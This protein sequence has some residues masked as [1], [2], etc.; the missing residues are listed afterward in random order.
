MGRARPEPSEARAHCIVSGQG[1]GADAQRVGARIVGTVDAPASTVRDVGSEAE[2]GMRR[3]LS[4]SMRRA[5]GVALLALAVLGGCGQ[6]TIEG[7]DDLG[8]LSED[9]GAGGET[10]G[11]DTATDAGGGDAVGTDDVVDAEA[12]AGDTAATDT[13]DTTVDAS[14]DDAADAQADVGGD[15]SVADAGDAATDDAVDAPDAATT[16]CASAADCADPTPA[17]DVATGACIACIVDAHC[18]TPHARCEAGACLPPKVCDDDGDC[19]ANKGV[20][21]AFDFC[22]DC[23]ED[24]DCGTGAVCKVFQCV[25]AGPGCA[26]AADCGSGEVCAE[27]LCTPPVCKPG[28][29]LCLQPDAIGSCKDGGDGWDSIGCGDG[30]GCDAAAC[31]PHVCPPGAKACAGEAPTFCPAN[32][33]GWQIAAP[34][35]GDQKCIDGACSSAVCEPGQTQCGSDGA[36]QTCNS[37]QTGWVDSTCPSGQACN[38]GVCLNV[39]CTPSESFCVGDT[40]W[41]CNPTGTSKT[42]VTDCSGGGGVCAEGACR[43]IPCKA[44]E[45]YCKGD[46]QLVCEAGTAWVTKTCAGAGDD[47]CVVS[48]CDPGSKQCKTGAQKSCDDGNPCTAGSC[49]AATG[50]CVQKPLAVPGGPAVTCDDGD[51]CTLV[52]VCDGTACT[53]GGETVQ[54]FSGSKIPGFVDGPADKARFGLPQDAARRPDGTL[55]VADRNNHRIRAVAAD[56]S[57]STFAGNGSAGYV[58]GPAAFAQMS[59]PSGIDVGAGWVVFTDRNN[60]RV[61]RISPTGQVS[62]FAGSGVAGDADGQGTAAQLYLPEGIVLAADGTMSISEPNRHRLRRIDAAGKVVTLAGSNKAGFADGK[63]SAALFNAP[64]GVDLG[65]SGLLYVADVGNHRIRAVAA[66]GTVTTVAGIGGGYADGAGVVAKFNGP[67]D[68]LWLPPVGKGPGALLIA[69][70]GNAVLR[71]ATLST[72]PANQVI[73]VVTVSGQAGKKGNVDGPPTQARWMLPGGLWREPLGFGVCDANAYALRRQVLPQ[74]ACD[75]GQPCT[76]DSCDKATGA[77]VHTPAAVGSACDDGDACTS[78]DAC[79]AKGLCLGALG[80]CDDGNACTAD[81]CDPWLG[82]CRHDATNEPCDDGQPCTWGDHC[83]GGACTSGGGWLAS[84]VGNGTPQA[85]DGIGPAA[86]LVGPARMATAAD[87]AVWLVDRDGHRVRRL[88]PKTLSLTTVAGGNGG[89]LDGTGDKARFNQPSGLDVRPDGAVVVADTG[90]HRL[91]LCTAAGVVTTLAGDGT[92]GFLDGPAAQARLHTPED[93]ALGPK[94]AVYVA[95]GGNRRIRRL[96]NGV[97]ETLA[98]S[99][100]VGMVDGT[101]AAARFGWPGGLLLEGDLLYVADRDNHRIRRVALGTGAVDT[102]IGSGKASFVDGVGVDAA[103]GWPIDLA[104]GGDGRLWVGSQQGAIVEVRG[105]S[106]ASRRVVGLLGG[107]YADG[108]LATARLHQARGL[109][110]FGDGVLVADGSNRRLR[111][112]TPEGPACTEGGPCQTS[113]SCDAKTGQ[114]VDST[115]KDGD[116]CEAGVC[117]VGVCKAGVCG[118]L[119]DKV[120][121]DG[122]ACTADLCDAAAGGCVHP[123][124]G[125][126]NGCCQ[127]V[128]W[129]ESFESEVSLDADPASLGLQWHVETPADATIPSEGKKVLRFG[130]PGGELAGGVGG[131]AIGHVRLAPFVVPVG[132]VTTLKVPV[133]FDVSPMNTSSRVYVRLRYKGAIANIGTVY[134]N[135]NGWQLVSRDLSPLAGKSVQLELRGQIPGTSTGAGIR[136]DQIRVEATCKAQTCSVNSQCNVS[137][138]GCMAGKCTSAACVMADN[139]CSNAD[140]CDDGKPC[141][142]DFC[143]NGTCVHEA[144]PG[145]C[146]ADAD[147]GAVDVCLAGKCNVATSACVYDAVPGCCHQDGDCD[148]GKPCTEDRCDDKNQCTYKELCCKTAADCSDGISCSVES[149]DAGWCKWA[150]NEASTCCKPL[151]G[152]EPAETPLQVVDWSRFKCATSSTV[153]TGCSKLAIGLTTSKGWQFWGASGLAHGGKGVLYYGDPSAKN[154]AFGAN[155]EALVSPAWKVNQGKTELEA[156][157]YWDT[158]GGTSYDRLLAWLWVDGQ[159]V[160]IGAS[161]APTYGAFWIKGV[162]GSTTPKTWQRIAVDVS[163][164]VGKKVQLELFFNTVDSAANTGLGVLLDDVR[165]VSTCTVGGPPATP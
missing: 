63:G 82:S 106:F 81:S 134:A 147:C 36:L 78:K 5:I 158:E 64:M 108:P 87:G 43:T 111:L 83:V 136:V 34:C 94:G 102:V 97:L 116:A 53:L 119:K 135:K 118:D 95:D 117:A 23:T 56:G 35:T 76:T 21:A 7:L 31:A 79:D 156:W 68:V 17:C 46:A 124:D 49:D 145:C 84:V 91:R 39:V 100:Q 14:T 38:K 41:L 15:T 69:D 13:V 70:T 55:L 51:G 58:D 159:R 61:R 90:N 33:Q 155:A 160:S 27:G 121:N 10:A 11:G 89:Y 144:K 40:L 30:N 80:S 138:L 162:A 96:A 62:T 140:E 75:D 47:K 113:G 60:H 122:V 103:I 165:L 107:G 112:L 154:F 52:D 59:Y 1:E 157:V 109:A 50:D 125:A 92:A 9:T 73:E 66:D 88:D 139:C 45:T 104:R 24:A 131:T 128:P 12:D 22:V 77:C 28:E 71:R 153:P 164:H 115:P 143:N 114:C 133:R 57:V 42:F 146:A 48:A 101:A 127:P 105:A 142:L 16:T 3:V 141:T 137:G 152:D 149:C 132:T 65:P 86:G 67:R 72:V 123:Q 32:G 85:V 150:F 99:G 93:I 25:P 148:D 20:C 120:C 2:G 18:P 19:A 161:T 126:A 26:S 8:G 37:T 151:G 163:A 29:S 44:G 130:V 129:A 74:V 110:A 98:G 4:I 6:V 54:T